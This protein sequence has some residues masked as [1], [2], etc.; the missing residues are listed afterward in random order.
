MFRFAPSPN[1]DLHLGHALSALLNHDLARATGGR[2][3]VRIEDID[4]SRA[5]PEFEARIL[6]DL[7]WLGIAYERPVR[8]QSAHGPDYR[9]ALDRL[10]GM[11]LV[12]TSFASRGEI[13]AFVAARPDWPHDPDGAPVYPGFG[14]DDPHAAAR[15]R[16]LA[17][18]PHALRLDM[19]RAIARAGTPGWREDAA[20][21]TP[22]PITAD[23]AA[24]GDVVLARKDAPA[25]YHLAVVV[26][27]GAQGVTDV[28]RGADL[29]AATAVHR[30][31]QQ[32]LGLPAPRYRHHRLV[33]GADGR[34]LSKS[35][36]AASLRTLRA[37]GATPA[38]VRRLVGLG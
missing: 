2:M 17:G 24:W 20:D 32:L 8:R 23:P 6:D 7:D 33:L 13:R 11:G 10:A 28:V 25:S 4:T 21:G 34:K 5:R 35:E 29:F 26:D 19:A 3:L 16:I 27:D 38:D 22:A 30:L 1:G 18:E 12:Y 14:R 15:T 36:G 31:L 37:E 9:A